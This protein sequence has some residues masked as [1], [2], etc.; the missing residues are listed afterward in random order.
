MDGAQRVDGRLGVVTLGLLMMVIEGGPGGIYRC[1]EFGESG[2][3]EGVQDDPP[4]P[5]GGDH[6]VVA[7][8]SQRRATEPVARRTTET[9]YSRCS[10]SSF[11]PMVSTRSPL[12]EVRSSGS[13]PAPP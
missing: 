10:Y 5:V 6:V 9:T 11:R 8:D 1:Q 4:L 12:A 2:V 13:K 3:G 7:E